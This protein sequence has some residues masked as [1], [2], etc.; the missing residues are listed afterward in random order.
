MNDNSK[1]KYEYMIASSPDSK[2]IFQYLKDEKNEQLIKTLNFSSLIYFIK[3]KEEF[4]KISLSTSN[5]CSSILIITN[6]NSL[7]I[8]GVAKQ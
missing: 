2:Y 5:L 8:I 4:G 7:E 1:D 3:K 6:L